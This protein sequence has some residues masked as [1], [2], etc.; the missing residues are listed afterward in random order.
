VRLARELEDAGAHILGIKDMAGL[1]KPEAARMLIRALRDEV[2]LPIHFHTHDT[3]G[4]AAASVLAAAE[5]GVDAVDAAMDPMSGL[6]SQPNLG[7]IVEAL[8]GSERDTGL[9]REPLAQ[10][11]VYWEAVRG[12]YAAFESDMRA[13]AAEVYEHEMPGGQYTN[14]RQQARALGIESRWREVARAYA[15]VNRMFGDIVKV[16]P[17][18]KVVGDLAVFMVTND[19]RPDQIL[20]PDREIAFPE[21][22]VEFFHGDLGQPHGG[23]PEGLQRKVLKG[24]EPLTVR[25]GEALPET[26]LRAAREEA[27]KKVRRSISDR[28][29]ASYLMYP[30][31]FLDY[32]DHHRV[33]GDV[34][35]LPTEAFFYGM[36]RDDE[37][38]VDIERGKTLVIR[39]LAVGDADNEGKRTI[40][41]ELNGQPREVKVADR[42]LAPSGPAKRTAD[43]GDPSHVPAPMPGLVVSLSVRIGEAVARGDRLLSIEAMKMETGVFAERA[44]AVR[45]ILVKA[46]DQVDT[47][48]L[49]MV[50][51]E[52]AAEASEDGGEDAGDAAGS[53]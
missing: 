3:S 20:D 4:I 46:G 2:G 10:L 6:T 9:D 35:V 44:G 29:L 11:A 48:Q 47:K 26:D 13:G 24:R 19:L 8:R 21:S 28:E 1:V 41:F 22:V 30:K 15:D 39:F 5:A 16:T 38:F 49:L 23:F 27:E 45:E 32:A 53:P 37:L 18:S 33:H 50:I 31:V 52:D 43:E 42:S 36:R 40:F 51:G 25:P 14:L 34:S 12:S 17:T 7:S